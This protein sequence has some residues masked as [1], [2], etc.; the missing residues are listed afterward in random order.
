[1]QYNGE[2]IIATST[3]KIL[4][5]AI[6]LHQKKKITIAAIKERHWVNQR[7]NFFNTNNFCVKYKYNLISMAN[8]SELKDSSKCFIKIVT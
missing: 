8:K 1:M 3:I 2:T 5:M 7:Q 6:S 4:T